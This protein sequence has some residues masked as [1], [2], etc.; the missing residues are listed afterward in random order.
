MDRAADDEMMASPAMVGA[1]AIVDQGA[2]E[3]GGGKGGDLVGDAEFDRGHV[4]GGDRFVE[5]GQQFGMLDR[6][7]AVRVEAAEADEEN[8]PPAAERA[9]GADQAGD[10][11]HLVGRCA[12][13]RTREEHRIAVDRR[14]RVGAHEREIQRAPR[15]H[16]IRRTIRE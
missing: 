12:H 15:L 8:L 16:V 9:A 14:G 6:E 5:L 10:D 4:K 2:A 13:G 1:V 7:R 3:V 11:L